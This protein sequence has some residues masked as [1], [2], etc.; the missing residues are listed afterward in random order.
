MDGDERGPVG[1][2]SEGGAHML[3]D[4]PDG[5]TLTGGG[6]FVSLP[7]GLNSRAEA[8]IV[9]EVLR[10]LAAVRRGGTGTVGTGAGADAHMLADKPLE[11]A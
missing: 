8:R 6:E 5:A 4:V 1:S 2:L 10:G 9:N 11:G 7:L 3:A